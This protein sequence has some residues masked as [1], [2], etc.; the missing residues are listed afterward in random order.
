[1][2]IDQQPKRDSHADRRPV[3]PH[4]DQVENAIDP[5]DIDDSC[6]EREKGM[7]KKPRRFTQ[8]DAQHDIPVDPDPDDPVSP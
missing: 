6:K 3:D 7:P 1:M 4:D 2:N 5:N 8:E